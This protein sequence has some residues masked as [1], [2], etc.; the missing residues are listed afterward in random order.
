MA[1]TTTM[2]RTAGAALVLAALQA[3]AQA[4]VSA[5]GCGPLQ[6]RYGPYDYR[7]EQVGHLPIV[8]EYHFTPE[9]EQLVHGKSSPIGGDIDYTLR[10]FP[11]HHRALLAMMRLG[12]KLKTPTPQGVNWP[13]ECYFER[14]IRFASDDAIVRN[15][16][17]LYLY[18][19]KRPDEAVAQLK[20][21]AMLAKDDAFTHYNVGLI[22]MQ[23]G[24]LDR[25][26]P[27]VQRAMQL[28]FPK[29]DLKDRLVAAG[30]W[31]EPPPLAASGAAGDAA[32]GAASSGPA[33][34]AAS[35]AS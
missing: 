33:T 22:Y 18:D 14:A 21:A 5:A 16:Y 31:V 6:N 2:W 35:A 34:A 17:A 9:V 1:A 25:A 20:V 4:Q 8:E 30:K 19:N 3:G 29:T 26:L 10:A 13:V 23:H 24:D 7:T 28:G 12:Q 32:S 15:L 27:E 11:N